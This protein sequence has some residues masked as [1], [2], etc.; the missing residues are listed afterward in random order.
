[1]TN[2]SIFQSEG[3]PG[4]RMLTHSLVMLSRTDTGSALFFPALQRFLEDG[5]R[6]VLKKLRGPTAALVANFL[7]EVRKPIITTALSCGQPT[8]L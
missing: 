7:D 6:R 5:E 3:E 4:S 8:T 2:I 1:M